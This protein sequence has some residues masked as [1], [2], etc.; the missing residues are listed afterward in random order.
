MTKKLSASL[1][2]AVLLCSSISG[3]DLAN[4]VS[5]GVY[6]FLPTAANTPGAFGA[7]FKTKI[8]FLNPTT[9]SYQV[10]VTFY[11]KDGKQQPSKSFSIAPNE[12]KSWDNFL[13]AFGWAGAGALQ[14][15]S[16]LDP[17][18]GSQDFE[19]IIS[20][21]IYTESPSGKYRT[22]V[23]VESGPVDTTWPAFSSGINV[24]SQERT[25]LGCV[26]FFQAQT[27]MAEIHG[28]DGT[29]L[30]TLPIPLVAY[31]WN[32]IPLNIPMTNGYVKW[33]PSAS[34]HCWAVVVNNKS[35][36]GNLIPA[37]QY[38]H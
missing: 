16:F 1:I 10:F 9:F 7:F 21:E 18:G 34:A 5:S 28:S 22:P 6:Q 14:F 38:L 12:L 8:D 24:T 23:E 33:I 15:D 13:E 17:P 31:G 37:I 26:S 19:F 2:L 25:N 36:D 30:D 29:T 32:Q 27:V 35:N 20:A 4:Q 11:N 3:K